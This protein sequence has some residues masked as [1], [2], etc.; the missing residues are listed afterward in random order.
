[1]P[2][3]CSNQL[4]YEVT[5][6]RA[7]QFVGL[8]FPRERNVHSPT[9]STDSENTVED[10]LEENDENKTKEDSPLCS[11]ETTK[12]PKSTKMPTKSRPKQAHKQ[13]EEE[14]FLLIKGIAN[15]LGQ[16]ASNKAKSGQDGQCE[17]FGSHVCET[18]QK[19]QPA[20]NFLWSKDHDVFF[21]REVLV[22]EPYQHKLRSIE[23]GRAWEQVAQHLNAIT[24]LKFR[25]TARSVRDRYTHLITKKANQL[26]YEEGDSEIEVIQTELDILLEE[27]IEREKDAKQQLELGV[28]YKK[29]K[30]ENEKLSAEDIC[31]QAMERMSQTAKRKEEEGSGDSSEKLSEEYAF[32][33]EKLP[34]WTKE[35]EAADKREREKNERQ[36]RAFQQQNEVMVA[37]MKQQQ[38]QMQNLQAMFLNQQQQQQTQALM[39]FLEGNAKK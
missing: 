21:C 20:T 1:M 32:K 39:A 6:L 29:R 2:V 31:K 3:Q 24:E 14:E 13:R 34:M 35:Q 37:L 5:Q 22:T 9:P 7:G 18:L 27:I 26:K 25:V 23:R 19:L 17:T 36:D 15:S 12:N 10:D 8:M 30:E 16:N 38:Q 33:Q 11:K 28:G 4:S